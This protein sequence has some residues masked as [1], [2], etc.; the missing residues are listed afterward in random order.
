MPA[1]EVS[2][3]CD[4]AVC[5]SLASCHTLPPPT[6]DQKCVLQCGCTTVCVSHGVFCVSVPCRCCDLSASCI[7]LHG[8]GKPP[9]HGGDFFHYRLPSYP[10][11]C[12]SHLPGNPA[13][14]SWKCIRPAKA[15]EGCRELLVGRSSRQRCYRTCSRLRFDLRSTAHQLQTLSK[16]AASVALCRI[17]GPVRECTEGVPR[18]L[19]ALRLM[20]NLLVAY[21][22][23]PGPFVAS[24]CLEDCSGCLGPLWWLWFFPAV[25]SLPALHCTWH[26]RALSFDTRRPASRCL[27]LPANGWQ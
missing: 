20:H 8:L 9:L 4:K 13:Y 26:G 16:A 21:G 15:L 18:L 17:S 10:C 5:A 1:C 23:V 7:A 24:C 2:R 14:Q 12:T 3:T 11:R 19:S 22:I 25:M 27:W 6:F